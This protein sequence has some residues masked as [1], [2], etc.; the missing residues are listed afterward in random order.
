M[1]LQTASNNTITLYLEPD[2]DYT[3]IVERVVA[4]KETILDSTEPIKAFK[5]IGFTVNKKD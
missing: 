3:I 2:E 1:K 4:S 5:P